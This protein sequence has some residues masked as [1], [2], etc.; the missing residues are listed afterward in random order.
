MGSPG[1]NGDFSG[2][3]KNSFVIENG[4]QGQALSESMISGNMA[5][6]LKDISGV[7]KEHLDL[8]GEDYPWI[9]IPNLHFS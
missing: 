9:R 2:V 1:A 7:S 6:M 8:G 5:E 4:E 3:I